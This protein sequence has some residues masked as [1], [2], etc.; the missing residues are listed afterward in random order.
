EFTRIFGAPQ[1]P[2]PPAQSGKPAGDFTSI[3][4]APPAAPSSIPGE[5]GWG[6]APDAAQPGRPRTDDYLSRLGASHAPPPTEPPPVT[7]PAS[8]P[9]G[10][11]SLDLPR[12]PAPPP[13][14]GE[15]TRIIATPQP[16][17]EPVFSPPPP[18][19]PQAVTPALAAGPAKLPSRIWL[20]VGLIVITLA[21]LAVV[22]V[23]VLVRAP[24]A[25]ADTEAPAPADTAAAP[26]TTPTNF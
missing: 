1:K 5:P 16:P 2:A 24:A 4:K 11:W 8:P 26:A 25:E 3:F 10:S 12:A 17:P 18:P 6:V 19:R 9:P 23:L 13:G 15:F 22:L 14:P 7:P 20:I 21:T